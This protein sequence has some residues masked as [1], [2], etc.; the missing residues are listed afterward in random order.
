MRADELAARLDGRKAGNGWSAKCPAHEDRNA[1]LSVAEGQDGCVLLKCHAG[2]A[3]D[4]VVAAI[5]IRMADLFPPRTNTTGAAR[6]IV[7]TYPYHDETGRM[8]F[9][10]VRYAP[11]DFRQ[12]KPNGAGGWKWT[13]AGV[14]LVPFRLPE[15]LAAISEGRAIYICEGEKDVLAIVAAG[16]A[17]TCNPMGAGKWRSEFSDLLTG[18]DCLIVPD[19][20]EPGRKH[21][22]AVAAGLHGKA[23][24]VRVVTLPSEFNGQRIKDA[25]DFFAAGGEAAQLDELAEQAPDWEPAGESDDQLEIAEQQGKE[26]D[27]FRSDI[28][29]ADA[30]VRRH[31]DRLRFIVEEKRWLIFDPAR[32]WLRDDTGQVRSLAADY[33]REL[34]R[35]ALESA[36]AMDPD[37]GKKLVSCMVTLGNGKRID[38]ALSFVAG[39]PGVVIQ[40]DRLDADPLLVGVENGVV[41]LRD[42]S[43]RPH[44]REHLVT[45]RLA[46][47][48]DASATA[49]T[50]EKFL[51]E[52]QPE[53]EM[54]GFLQRLA[55]YC[56]SGEVREHYLPFH[57][58]TGANGKG[59]F[60][61]HA[62]LKL[63]GTYGAK[64][65]DS[66]VY[67]SDR[68]ALP[69]LE[70]ANLCGK[71]FALGEENSE[72]GKLNEALLKS[73]TGGD[74]QKGRFHYGNFLEYFPTYKIQLVGNHQPRIDGTDDGIWRRFLLVDWPV[75][76]PTDRRDP[77]LK[78][79]LAAEMPGILNWC[80]AGAREWLAGGLR[81]PAS[82]TEA[83]AAFRTKSDELAEFIA[84]HFV[85]A[86]DSYVTKADMFDRY[87]RW[88]REAGVKHPK[89]KRALGFALVNRGWQEAINGHEKARVWLGWR[90][91]NRIED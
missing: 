68:G 17:A 84:D 32:G 76:I 74:R 42:G 34:Y 35:D 43:F 70:L 88:A 26:P 30:I 55:G 75:Q 86:P 31:G 57:F 51:G 83:T 2:C 53:P 69:H 71:R 40:A 47:R 7:A 63:A 65:T 24:R 38:P 14:R 66:L 4:A 36:K 22:Q 9:E 41:N 44:A 25:A 58:G 78:D 52:V 48:F 1:S 77:Q 61:E 90:P 11:K 82:C 27:H 81:P 87:E 12:R 23:A 20:D 6:R 16:F 80:L 62:L 8:L 54:R 10:A 21:A 3:S 73:I 59:T 29:Y 56:L 19:N 18:G 33:A 64:L 15:T 37:V 72:G 91:I 79:K 49:P 13:L 89:S 60:L 39:N 85:E 67:H 50:W 28:G 5:G 46:T 45:R